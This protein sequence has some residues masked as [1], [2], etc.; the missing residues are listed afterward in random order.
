MAQDT[1]LLLTVFAGPATAPAAAMTGCVRHHLTTQGRGELDGDH[2]DA[3]DLDVG[4]SNDIHCA[5]ERRRIVSHIGRPQES[6]FAMDRAR[7]TQARLM[8][9]AHLA[10]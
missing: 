3:F 10:I 5:D 7:Q 6:G 8:S 2:R 1:T 9:A 4:P